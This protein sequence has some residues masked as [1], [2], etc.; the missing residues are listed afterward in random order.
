ML[1]PEAYRTR[2]MVSGLQV[3]PVSFSIS[4]IIF[5]ALILGFT[6]IFLVII[7]FSLSLKI[8]GRPGRDLL[9]VFPSLNTFLLFLQCGAIL[10]NHVGFSALHK[11]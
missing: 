11:G 4:D 9:C 10:N 7:R 3:F 6:I 1:R 5:E 2:R 8:I